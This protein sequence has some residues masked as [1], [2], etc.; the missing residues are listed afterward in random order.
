MCCVGARRR[1]RNDQHNRIVQLNAT[2]TRRSGLAAQVEPAPDDGST[3]KHPDLQ[4]FFP[5]APIQADVTVREPAA[6]WILNAGNIKAGVAL[7]QAHSSK[8]GKYRDQAANEGA[9]F[10]TFAVETHGSL[11]PDYRATLKALTTS[12]ATN[13]RIPNTK[14]YRTKYYTRLLQEVSVCLQRGNAATLM[15]AAARYKRSLARTAR[16]HRGDIELV[17]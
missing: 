5:D 7:R 2:Q 9:I 12:A 16:A 15:K 8:C 17:N 3:R 1:E 6:P 13:C 4:L 10:K 11:H 14:I